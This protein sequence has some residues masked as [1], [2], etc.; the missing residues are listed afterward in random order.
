MNDKSRLYNINVKTN[1][2]I[3]LKKASNCSIKAKYIF[4]IYF[5]KY[6]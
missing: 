6:I 5:I 2:K 4:Q 3:D 1:F